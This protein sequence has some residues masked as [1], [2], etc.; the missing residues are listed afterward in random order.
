MRPR[1]AILCDVLPPVAKPISEGTNVNIPDAHLTIAL[2]VLDYLV[3]CFRAG[4][5]LTASSVKEYFNLKELR[6]CE[7]SFPLNLVGYAFL[8]R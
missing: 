2:L 6:A 4:S 3:L 7:I 8:T 5:R 1:V